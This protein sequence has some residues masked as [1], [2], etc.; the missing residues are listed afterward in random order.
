MRTKNRSKDDYK[1]EII[2]YLVDNSYATVSDLSRHFKKDRYYM[3]LIVKELTENGDIKREK[4]R[5]KN[6]AVFVY[7]YGAS[8][9]QLKKQDITDRIKDKSYLDYVR[10]EL[11]FS[12][13]S[14]ETEETF[15]KRYRKWENENYN[16]MY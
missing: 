5:I 1:I 3:N 8:P 2:K 14:L 10:T 11:N 6:K 16:P 9:V 4:V 15:L 12:G 13:T 7:S